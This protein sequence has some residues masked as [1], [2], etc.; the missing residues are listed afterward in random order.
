MITFDHIS[1]ASQ[2]ALALLQNF[3]ID[4]VS[5]RLPQ[6]PEA[7]IRDAFHFQQFLVAAIHELRSDPARFALLL[8]GAAKPKRVLRSSQSPYPVV[9]DPVIR[10][11]FSPSDIPSHSNLS[12]GTSGRRC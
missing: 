7:S 3:V 10:D 6:F 8:G 9:K 2:L 1:A 4:S 11:V 12:A 5:C